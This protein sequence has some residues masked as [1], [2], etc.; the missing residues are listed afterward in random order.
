MY[1]KIW[2]YWGFIASE[3]SAITGALTLPCTERR[4]QRIYTLFLPCCTLPILSHVKLV[5]RAVWFP[6]YVPYSSKLFRLLDLTRSKRGR[7]LLDVGKLGRC[8][9][10]GRGLRFPSSFLNPPVDILFSFDIE[11]LFIKQA[12][13]CLLCGYSYHAHIALNQWF[14]RL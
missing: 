7:R 12:I 6:F 4:H 3:K 1:F 2:C 9:L 13:S 11:L 10:M 14:Q 5:L 8:D